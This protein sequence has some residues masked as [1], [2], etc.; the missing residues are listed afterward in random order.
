MVVLTA[1]NIFSALNC[2]EE[3]KI[4]KKKQYFFQYTQ[5]RHLE[6]IGKNVC[7]GV[8]WHFQQHFSEIAYCTFNNYVFQLITFLLAQIH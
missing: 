2:K 3:K 5:N 8:D 1:L 4:V 7:L 6:N